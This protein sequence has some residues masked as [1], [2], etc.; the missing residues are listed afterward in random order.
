MFWRCGAPS[1]T[2]PGARPLE[3]GSW[4]RG[5]SHRPE[6]CSPMRG[7]SGSFLPGAPICPQGKMGADHRW[8]GAWDRWSERAWK[9]RARVQTA[10]DREAA[11]ERVPCED[12]SYKCPRSGI[13]AEGSPEYDAPPAVTSL[14]LSGRSTT[15]RVV[16]S[17]LVLPI[18]VILL[19]SLLVT[20]VFRTLRIILV[21]VPRRSAALLA[22]ARSRGRIGLGGI[23][24]WLS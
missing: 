3:T 2:L 19:V 8:A 16:A 6:R 24:T 11:V 22:S 15:C 13:T 14:P 20:G 18:L 1:L 9:A 4:N 7:D 10:L 23:G 12:I 5:D 17:G 21:D